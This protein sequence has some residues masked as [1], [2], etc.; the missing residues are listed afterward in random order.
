MSHLAS[1]RYLPATELTAALAI[2]DLTDPDQGR[3]ALQ[4]ILSQLVAAVGRDAGVP[5]TEHRASA[6]VATA[7]NYDRLGYAPD[8]ITRDARYS[9]HVSPSVMLR[10]HTTAGIPGIL[11]GLRDAPVDH[12]QLVAL[13]GLVYRRDSIDRTHVGT[14]HQLDLWRLAH[15]RRLGV[16]DLHQLARTVVT[17][18][19]PGARWR[20]I[21]AV[22]PYTSHGLQVEVSIDG[23]W[24]E[25]AECGLVGHTVLRH[26]DLDP[27]EWSGLALG[28]GLDRALMIRKGIGDIRLLRSTHP[29]AVRQLLDL[30]P[31]RPVSVMPAIRRDIS[32]VADEAADAEL[33]GDLAR[34]AL[35]A[36][37]DLLAELSVL[38][39]TPAGQLPAGAATRLRI[40]PDQHNLLLRLT[41]QA[42]DRTL[43]DA[44][45]NQLRDRVYRALH[46]GP[47]LE[48]IAS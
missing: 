9:R 35:D 33:L 19:L 20:V 3:H 28:L 5:V 10:S 29:E 22:H 2:R 31:W 42:L 44:E 23:E 13:P 26:C 24:L 30:E 17:T 47:D 37:A 45:A 39:D 25:L 38:A 11:D 7:D 46:R 1:T 34:T 43:T 21:P 12:D 40:R 6:L 32:I 48:L 27:R 18:V 15:G 8:D 16:D 4:L 41:W 36:E 14:P